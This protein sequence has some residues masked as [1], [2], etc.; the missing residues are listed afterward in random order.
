MS[1]A[2]T[3]ATT[4]HAQTPWFSINQVEARC[5]MVK[6][7]PQQVQS[8]L[9]VDLGHFVRVRVTRDAAGHVTTAS[10]YDDTAGSV[11]IYFHSYADC[12]AILRSLQLPSANELR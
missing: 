5:I 11:F 8:H 10:I 4:A 3:L 6:F 2:T 7:S 9:R 1:V 12:D